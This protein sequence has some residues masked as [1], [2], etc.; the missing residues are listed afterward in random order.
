MFGP[1]PSQYTVAADFNR[2]GRLD[3]A[4]DPIYLSLYEPAFGERTP[5][6]SLR[7]SA[8]CNYPSSTPDHR[9]RRGRSDQCAPV[10]R[11]GSGTACFRD[12]VD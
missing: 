1:E 12:P 7:L 9:E 11:S 5:A 3:V 4:C 10:A 6:T 2:D 8:A